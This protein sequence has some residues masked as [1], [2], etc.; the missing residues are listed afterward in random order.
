MG[1]L[2]GD[3]PDAIVLQM[4]HEQTIAHDDAINVEQE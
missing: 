1:Q 2:G 3:V 4:F